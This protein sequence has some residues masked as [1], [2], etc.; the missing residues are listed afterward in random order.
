MWHLTLRNVLAH[1]GRFA[2]TLFAVVLAVSFAAGSLTLTGTSEKLLDEQF[3]TAAAGVDITVR[4]AAAFDSAMGVEVDRDPLPAGVV[5]RLLRVPGV[6]S[7]LPAVDGQGLLVVGGE[8]VVPPGASVLASWS[9]EPFGAF[10]L[11][12]GRAPETVGEVVVDLETA[13]T[14]GIDIGDVVDVTTDSRTSLRVVGLVGF[15][16]ADGMP[17]ATV[18]LVTLEQAQRM[19]GLGDGLSEVL[20]TTSGTQPVDQVLS[21]VRSVL[22]DEYAVASAQDTAAASADAAQEQLGSLGMVLTVMS[23]AALLVGSLLIANTFAIVTSQRRREIAL[24]RAAGATAGQVTRAVLGEALVV[25]AV[26]SVIGTGLGLVAAEGLRELVAVFGTELPEGRAAVSASSVVLP[27]GLGLLVTVLSAVAAARGAART[28]PVEA[29]RASA[30]IPARTKEHGRL[31]RAG[32][33]VPLVAG[34]AGVVSVLAG[35]PVLVLVPAALLTVA[36]TAVQGRTITPALARFV[37]APLSRTGVPGHLARESAARAPRRTTSTVMALAL[38]LAL[39]SFMSV[40]A[41]SLKDG[42]SGS[43]GET[44]T[45]DLVVESARGEMLG[46]LSPQVAARVGDLPDVEQVS[47][48]RYGHWL[49][50]GTTSALSAIDPATLPLVADLDLVAGSLRAL[51][52][53]GVVVAESVADERGLS[54]GDKVTMTFSYTG[55]QELPVVGILDSL[56]AQALATSWFVSMDTYSRNFTEDVDASV[57]VRLAD[58]VDVTRARSQ[59]E[60]SLEDHPTADVR[61][62]AAAAAARG[63]TVE[64]VL[65]LV[66]VLLVLTVII[67]LLGITNTL[68]LS[69]SERTREIGLLRAVGANRRQ[70]SWMVRAEA[71]LVAALAGVL[72]LGLGV[73][74]GAVTV[75]ALGRV[76]P[77]AISM[78]VGRLTLVAGVAAAAGL[79]AGLLPARRAARMDV[80][81]A[82]AAQ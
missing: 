49:D 35:A 24:I 32:R 46:G 18:A 34:V 25:G 30:E 26:G 52:A 55:D 3:R 40:V 50:G 74:L 38:S 20:L 16:D 37:G 17:G 22:G 62:H 5:D 48:V 79:V 27:V 65:G 70:I 39:I 61:D 68:A 23:A 51:E 67:A 4:D 54:V 7:A 8:P 45:A 71:V 43:Y 78:P 57:L 10:G 12:Q 21:A 42:L 31:R 64:Q 56:D 75:A 19:L 66:T 82:I 59:I 36:G 33:L 47:R 6:E 13:R 80:L 11:R 72:G 63:A 60:S 81:Q 29:L 58:G 73:G 9:P 41:T 44:V 76:A 15:A 69:V 28:A 53:G 1:R 77:L 2:L 14:A